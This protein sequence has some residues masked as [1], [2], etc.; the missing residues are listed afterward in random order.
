VRALIEFRFGPVD[1]AFADLLEAASARTLE[2]L[3]EDARTAKTLD[4]LRRV[5]S[6]SQS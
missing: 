6:A 1:R 2:R 4:E 5:L 3:T